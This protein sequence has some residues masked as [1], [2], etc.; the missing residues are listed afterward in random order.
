MD[1]NF[2]EQATKQHVVRRLLGV[3]LIF[4][5]ILGIP[6]TGFAQEAVVSGAVTDNTGGVLPGAVVRAVH[7]ASGNSFEA[8][9]DGAGE[10][11]LAVRIGGYEII[12]ELPGF[13][14]LVQQ[15][16][17]LQVGQEV[18][19]SLELAISTLEETVTVTGRSSADRC[20]LVVARGQHRRAADG[21]VAAEWP[22]L[23]GPDDA[24]TREPAERLVG[25]KADHRVDNWFTAGRHFSDQS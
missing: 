14:T 6:V 11:R 25:R 18:T 13:T 15:G 1:N 9:T 2:T 3:G 12:A 21:G 17:E 23:D 20:H 22:E 8:V 10:F 16:L 19:V 4:G 5:L 24:C 7:L